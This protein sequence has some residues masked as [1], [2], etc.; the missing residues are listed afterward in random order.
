[1]RDMGDKNM[2]SD[3]ATEADGTA[4]EQSYAA[5]LER[6]RKRRTEVERRLHELADENRRRREEADEQERLNEIR[7][8][9]RESGVKKTELAM[10]V[11]ERDVRRDEDGLLY[12]EVDGMKTPLNEFLGRFL[13][14]NPE[15]LPP[16][17]A[18]GSGVPAGESS[19]LAGGPVQMDEIRPGM[20]A[21]AASRAWKEVARL[22]G[23]R[24]QPLG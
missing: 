11:L 4:V 9:L 5:A 17:I 6:E 13:S 16:R 22:M 14:D 2:P 15:F 19:H 3:H 18:G 8:G 24:E 23:Q 10:R 7:D 21:E 1:M 20:N 12:G